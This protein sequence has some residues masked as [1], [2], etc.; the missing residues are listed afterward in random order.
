MPS[1]QVITFDV[2]GTAC[3][4]R[5]SA[6]RE[7]LPLPRLWRPPALPRPVAGF[8]NLSG[9]A[10]PVLGLAILFGLEQGGAGAE[11]ELYRHLILVDGLGRD[12]GQDGGQD[13]GPSALLVDRVLDVT[14]I[15]PE[16]LSP[17]PQSDSL[18]GCIE[19]EISLGGRLVHLLS[20]ERILL[21]EERHALAELNHDA[22][23]RLSQWAVPA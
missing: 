17:V 3:A 6:V 18:N 22:Q 20:P 16:Q 4:L 1:Q 11:A 21:A 7:L 23:N 10:V 15:D 14:A 12:G 8:F 2:G 5:R 13:D 9:R 19:A